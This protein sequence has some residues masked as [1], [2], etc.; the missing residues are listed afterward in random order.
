MWHY[1]DDGS[2]V[3][4]A[5][6]ADL[7]KAFGVLSDSD[8]DE[9]I[10]PGE[11]RLSPEKDKIAYKPKDLNAVKYLVK[12]QS[13]EVD[14]S[15]GVESLSASS[16]SSANAL[17]MGASPSPSLRAAAL[18]KVSSGA[19]IELRRKPMKRLGSEARQEFE[20]ILLGDSDF[21]G[22][23]YRGK[24]PAGDYEVRV[25]RGN[26]THVS[27]AE[28]SGES[29]EDNY[30]V[31]PKNSHNFKMEFFLDSRRA[32]DPYRR[33]HVFLGE[34]FPRAIVRVSNVG[35]VPGRSLN[36]LV[37]CDRLKGISASCSPGYVQGTTLKSGESLDV[38][39]ELSSFAG[40]QGN[41]NTA[42][43]PVEVYDGAG[44]LWAKNLKFVVY[45]RAMNLKAVSADSKVKLNGF[46]IYPSGVL[47]RFGD[48]SVDLSVP[49]D[50]ARSSYYVGLS[51]FNP[52]LDAAIELAVNYGLAVD[53]A[54]PPIPERMLS[55]ADECR[56]FDFTSNSCPDRSNLGN[57]SRKTANDVRFGSHTFGHVYP[58]DLDFFRVDISPEKVGGL[59]VVGYG[60]DF[61]AFS[62]DAVEG[63]DRYLVEGREGGRIFPLRT[64]FLRETRF[65]VDG[66]PKGA[67]RTV[68]VSACNE[69]G[70][71]KPAEITV[72]NVD[73]EFPSPGDLTVDS[74]SV[75][76]SG[77][78]VSAVFFADESEG[79]Q[80][81][82]LA[83]PFLR[84]KSVFA[85]ARKRP[86]IY[87]RRPE[88]RY[89]LFLPGPRLH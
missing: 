58:G 82:G 81:H 33:R 86:Q 56:G 20:P 69:S 64:D 15:A 73:A 51:N 11:Y 4:V 75:A 40:L 77:N 22:G 87:R 29:H 18:G 54:V 84:R 70:C 79:E 59:S 76:V 88:F 6:E 89:A 17:L 52:D 74:S 66:F 31:V 57:N 27:S 2:S 7:A 1:V 10:G 5:E 72:T 32:D 16:R 50:P 25:A 43:L 24:V 3:Y 78:S 65:S 68:L 83:G 28:I 23:S 36:V 19:S 47:E 55:F 62:F 63:A 21:S 13:G 30:K 49:Y 41:K 26:E 45:R 35:D 67:T 42:E 38:P 34:G 53:K 85:N 14:F 9:N 8:R 80:N 12:G 39:V 71:S 60:S 46:L 44:N 37:L 61:V 48:S